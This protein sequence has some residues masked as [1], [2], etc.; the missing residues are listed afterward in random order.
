M[1]V[2]RAPL[3]VAAN[4]TA[5]EI[6]RV[7]VRVGQTVTHGFQS[8]VEVT[9]GNALASGSGNVCC[10]D[11]PGDVS[12]S[13]RWASRLTSAATPEYHHATSDFAG[14]KMQVGQAKGR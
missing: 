9:Y 13:G 11:F 4:L 14:R 3:N 2:P 6:R 8:G 1:T 5:G 7:H 10:S 12:R